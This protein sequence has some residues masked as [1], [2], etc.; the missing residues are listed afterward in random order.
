MSSLHRRGQNPIQR[1]KN[2]AFVVI[3]LLQYTLSVGNYASD[4]YNTSF[5]DITL[6]LE[7]TSSIGLTYLGI[8]WFIDYEKRKI[9]DQTGEPKQQISGPEFKYDPLIRISAVTT[10]KIYLKLFN[11]SW[12]DYDPLVKNKSIDRSVYPIFATTKTNPITAYAMN[13]NETKLTFALKS[14]EVI[15]ID[16]RNFKP[17]SQPADLAERK[18]SYLGKIDA[19]Y[20]IGVEGDEEIRSIGLVPYSDFIIFSPSRFLIFKALRTESKPILQ[21]RSFLDSIRHIVLPTPTHRP[22]SDPHNPKRKDNPKLN[23]RFKELF[24]RPYFVATGHL[25]GDNVFA[26]W[27]SLKVVNYWNYKQISSKAHNNGYEKSYTIRSICYFGG[28]TDAQLYPFL[29][30]NIISELG[31]FKADFGTI[32]G[33]IPLPKASFEGFVT[34]VNATNYVY[35]S[36]KDLVGSA[37][38][39][40]G[41]YFLNLGPY[42]IQEPLFLK[43]ID[44]IL[45]TRYIHP[46]LLAYNSDIT[47]NLSFL[48]LYNNI[49][50]FYLFVHGG[51]RNI[52]VEV[53]PFNWD[54]CKEISLQRSSKRFRMYSGR[55]ITCKLSQ[56]CQPGFQYLLYNTQQT[57]F[58]KKEILLNCVRHRCPEGKIVHFDHYGFSNETLRRLN[59][60]KPLSRV[61]G[62]AAD[63]IVCADKYKTDPVEESEASD[64]GCHSEY[65]LDPS[66]ICRRCPIAKYWAPNINF[67]PRF[68]TSDCVFY[69]YPEYLRWDGFSYNILNYTEDKLFERAG[70]KKQGGEEEYFSDAGKGYYSRIFVAGSYREVEV[71]ANGT[72]AV[73]LRSKTTN[74]PKAVIG[75]F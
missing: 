68:A 19:R 21:K 51:S 34:W 57:Q 49:D 72:T 75:L 30:S 73:P 27:T 29:A 2:A 69:S 65:N 33:T 60:T 11:L 43:E 13:N 12:V 39:N 26:D 56:G 36:Q 67:Y 59:G 40:F 45:N 24:S 4:T 61:W 25:S 42:S 52:I 23:Q 14:L 66:G 18:I 7:N 17:G 31:L 55:V 44:R 6:R 58:D 20:K 32:R 50:Y 64:N 35:I 70:Y 5:K 16:L 54:V 37:D 63:K 1:I 41:S 74:Y 15:T 71:Y 8:N 53:A 3:P 47:K 9:E 48:D 28:N 62:W 10:Q 46:T 38:F 22:Q